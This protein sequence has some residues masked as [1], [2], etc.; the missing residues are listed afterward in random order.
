[1]P[2]SRARAGGSF[3]RRNVF[4]PSAKNATRPP[5]WS[6]TTSRPWPSG[7]TTI[8]TCPGRC[9][10]RPRRSGRPTGRGPR[11]SCTRNRTAASGNIGPAGCFTA[12]GPIAA[13]CSGKPAATRPSTTAKTRP[14][15]GGC[16]APAP[17]RPTPARWAS[18]P[19]TFTV[20]AATAGIC[21]AWAATGIGGS[22]AVRAEKTRLRIVPAD[23][24]DL[25]PPRI[26][27]GVFPRVFCQMATIRLIRA[28]PAPTGRGPGNG[29]FALQR[30]LRQ[31]RPRG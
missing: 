1:M 4:P 7:T 29:Q 20:G 13:S 30:A 22:G 12:A 17:R 15:P 24:L 21:R 2:T 3:P 18:R 28:V 11:W 10:P 23:G 14:W 9:R 16:S 26:L 27:P 31:L 6:A 8:F 5:P 19:F 25:D